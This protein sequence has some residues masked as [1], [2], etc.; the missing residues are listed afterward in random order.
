MR[1]SVDESVSWMRVS[2]DECQWITMCHW[3]RVCDDECVCVSVWVRGYVGECHWMGVPEDE[4]A[5]G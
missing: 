4:S 5:S 2:V 1:V 3:M